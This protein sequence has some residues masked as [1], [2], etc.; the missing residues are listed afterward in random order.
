MECEVV[1]AALSARLDG[2]ASGV[3]D[4]VVDAHLS[5]CADCRAWFDQAV[6]LNR[7]LLIGPADD[8][9]Q[10]L[11]DVS[12]PFDD[13]PAEPDFTALSEKILSTV[14]PE[15]RRR[16]R[17]WRLVAGTARALLVVLGALYL[18]WGVSLIGDVGTY[19]PEGMAVSESDPV[20]SLALDAAAF[21]FALAVGMFWAAWR[22]RAAMGMAPLYGAAA[23]FSA[24]FATRDIIVGVFGLTDF[25]QIALLM[26]SAVALV[27][28]WIGSFGPTAIAQAWRGASGRPLPGR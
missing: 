3:D 18:A 24:G 26:A 4:D 10:K 6:R 7:S 14:E 22:P 15:R 28:V 25:A 5:A 21:R 9:E 1:R 12:L 27:V 11:P 17:S 2:E 8:K 16:E 20:V 13:E 23:M 19:L